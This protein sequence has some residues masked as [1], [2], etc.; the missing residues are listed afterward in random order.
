MGYMDDGSHPI[1]R[2]YVSSFFHRSFLPPASVLS[3]LRFDSVVYWSQFHR[4]LFLVPSFTLVVSD[5][6]RHL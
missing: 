5:V 3:P 2:R 1:V 6:K 4:L